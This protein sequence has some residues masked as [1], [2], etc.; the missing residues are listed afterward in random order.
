MLVVLQ[1]KDRANDENN[2]G[3]VQNRVSLRTFKG[4]CAHIKQG[5]ERIAS[6][7]KSQQKKIVV[8]TENI[9]DLARS[10]RYFKLFKHHY[11]GKRHKRQN[12]RCYPVSLGKG[13]EA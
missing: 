13:N 3:T 8:K 5:T 11:C 7:K 10:V 12:S 1:A 2:G 9:I 4:V 6:G